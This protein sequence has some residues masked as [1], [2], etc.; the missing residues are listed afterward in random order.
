MPLLSGIYGQSGRWVGG[1]ALV[2]GATAGFLL[3]A[4]VLAVCGG[5]CVSLLSLFSFDFQ[6]T[7]VSH[8]LRSI[9][10]RE[11]FAPDGF[12]QKG[13]SKRKDPN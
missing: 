9:L 4:V 12:A 7:D 3:L 11:R 2:D 8:V 13:G 6:G 10:L 1:T 5:E